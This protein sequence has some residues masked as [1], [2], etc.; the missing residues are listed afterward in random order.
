M[1]LYAIL[2]NIYLNQSEINISKTNILSVPKIKK[3]KVNTTLTLVLLVGSK[4]IF[5]TDRE[6]YSSSFYPLYI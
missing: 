2:S 1:F 5:A 6:G 3:L 4:S